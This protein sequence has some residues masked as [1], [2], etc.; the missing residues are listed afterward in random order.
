MTCL[1]VAPKEAARL[2]IVTGLVPARY[3][4]AT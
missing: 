4:S 1:E 2:V 3:F